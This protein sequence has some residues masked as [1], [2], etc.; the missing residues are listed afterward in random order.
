MRRNG[1]KTELFD[2]IKGM[3]A[4]KKAET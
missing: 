1:A 2:H 3:F 4:K